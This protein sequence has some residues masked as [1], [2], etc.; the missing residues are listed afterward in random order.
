[1]LI[2]IVIQKFELKSNLHF[3]LQQCLLNNLSKTDPTPVKP[4]EFIKKRLNN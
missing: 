2:C 1:M 3:R 4:I